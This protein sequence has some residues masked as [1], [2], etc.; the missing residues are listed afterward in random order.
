[1]VDGELAR[2]KKEAEADKV[3]ILALP[4]TDTILPNLT[5]TL[6]LTLL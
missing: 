5:L 4:L 2:L 3:L 6:L 1:M